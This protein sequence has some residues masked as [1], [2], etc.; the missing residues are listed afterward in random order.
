MSTL[1]HIRE[2]L[3]VVLASCENYL[4]RR[5]NGDDKSEIE[6]DKVLY[7]K[8]MAGHDHLNSL[9]LQLISQ[10]TGLLQQQF[11]PKPS[12][13]PPVPFE[14]QT[15]P[16]QPFRIE[17]GYSAPIAETR[18][19]APIQQPP[20]TETSLSATNAI[21]DP[22]VSPISSSSIVTPPV[23]T[24]TRSLHPSNQF[25]APVEE[26]APASIQQPTPLETAQSVR[27]VIPDAQAPVSTSPPSSSFVPPVSPGQPVKQRCPSTNFTG[28]PTTVPPL[29]RGIFQSARYKTGAGHLVTSESPPSF[30]PQIPKNLPVIPT[31][32]SS[33]PDTTLFVTTKLEETQSDDNRPSL[34]NSNI[35][36]SENE[37]KETSTISF[38]IENIAELDQ[39][40]KQNPSFSSSSP[41]GGGWLPKSRSFAKHLRKAH[42]FFETLIKSRWKFGGTSSQSREDPHF[43]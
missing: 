27:N 28:P 2:E 31:L 40:Q 30:E 24:E 5:M 43:Y 9:F 1:P 38:T 33:Q 3:N 8:C 25:S 36:C 26:T 35:I 42:H 23:S 13:Q 16:K 12:T 32:C 37:S 6:K 17:S 4:Q 21:P 34:C 39:N 7:E 29:N 20:Q 22:S 10:M 14:E 11:I 15:N 41:P 19:T 18:I